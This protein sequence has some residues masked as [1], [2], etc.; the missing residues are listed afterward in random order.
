MSSIQVYTI[1]LNCIKV[2][3]N[4]YQLV[5]LKIISAFDIH[6][7]LAHL[8]FN[9]V[10]FF[11]GKMSVLQVTRDDDKNRI[12]KAYHEMARKHHPDRQKTSEDKI[13]AEERFRLI[14]TAYEVCLI[15]NLKNYI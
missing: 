7:I 8:R 3:D 2:S 13:K 1:L 4:A 10:C 11:W 6:I 14:N 15:S 5:R 12:R 9:F